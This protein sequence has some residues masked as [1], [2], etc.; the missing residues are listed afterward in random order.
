MIRI[1]GCSLDALESWDG[2]HRESFRLFRQFKMN[3]ER[4]NNQHDRLLIDDALRMNCDNGN[5]NRWRWISDEI[6]ELRP[7]N[8]RTVR[9]DEIVWTRSPGWIHS[10][11]T[12]WIYLDTLFVVITIDFDAQ[13]VPLWSK[14]AVER[15]KRLSWIGWQA[16]TIVRPTNKQPLFTS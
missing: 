13:I 16:R 14:D 9:L 4:M 1:F 3:R 15:M 12:G 11:S 8:R 7:L 2:I 6:F 5:S 10:K